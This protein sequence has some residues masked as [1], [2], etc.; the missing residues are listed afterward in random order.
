MFS[1]FNIKQIILSLFL[2]I[3]CGSL[4][5][6]L[7]LLFKYIA[8]YAIEFSSELY[9]TVSKNPIYL[10]LLVLGV[11]ILSFILYSIIK[12]D[13]VCKGAG[14]PNSISMVKNNLPFRWVTSA[15]LL[16]FAALITFLSGVPLGNEGPSVQMGCA[17]GKG[18][19]NFFKKDREPIS[20]YILSGGMSAGFACVTGSPLTAIFFAFEELHLSLSPLLV[21]SIIFAS[22]TSGIVTHFL[23]KT[24]NIHAHLFEFEIKNVLSYKYV[25]IVILLGF[26]VGISSVLLKKLYQFADTLLNSKLNKIPVYIKFAF[27]FIITAIL[28]FVSKDFVGTG[29]SLINELLL[30]EKSIWY[31]LLIVLLV[32]SVLIAFATKSG[33]TGGLFI[34]TLT[35]GA[36]IGFLFAKFFVYLTLL[37]AEYTGIIIIISICS[38]LAAT[39]KIPI[40][41]LIFAFETFSVGLN[42]IY[43]LISIFLAFFISKTFE[44][45]KFLS[46]NIKK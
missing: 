46:F 45:K 11:V 10:P 40:T 42:G 12:Y 14:I 22:A 8:S 9:Q 44:E 15:F 19:L 33:I 35:L 26:A 41:A 24:L 23:S 21:I 31:F 27:I 37:P 16:P 6:V 29:H 3:I 39:T 2:S 1:K 13:S 28:G 36:I 38:F 18:T 20:R 7:I 34:P 25:L 32:R 43:V 17:I 5:A 30:D 4:T